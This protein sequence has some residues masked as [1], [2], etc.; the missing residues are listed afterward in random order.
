MTTYLLLL[1]SLLRSA[2]VSRQHLLLEN[3]ALRQQLAVLSR[4]SAR[5]R[6]EPADLCVAS[7]ASLSAHVT[8]LSIRDCGIGLPHRVEHISPRNRGTLFGRAHISEQK[9]GMASASEADALVLTAPRLV[10]EG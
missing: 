5:P 7:I 1:W 4:R 9:V 6:L 10:D 8:Q 3:L 2:F